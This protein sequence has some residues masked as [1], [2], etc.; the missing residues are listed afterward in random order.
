MEP[1]NGAI[2]NTKKQ[3]KTSNCQL[4][5]PDG[6]PAEIVLFGAFY[7]TC[8]S[9]IWPRGLFRY[10]LVR[11]GQPLADL[12]SLR[13]GLRDRGCPTDVSRAVELDKYVGGLR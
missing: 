2:K 9:G 5:R 7:N 3:K 8:T 13:R 12:W 1:S 11:I 6:A 10:A 4:D